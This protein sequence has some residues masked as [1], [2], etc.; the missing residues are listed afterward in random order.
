MI[1]QGKNEILFQEN[2]SAMIK[3]KVFSEPQID[4]VVFKISAFDLEIKNTTNVTTSFMATSLVITMHGVNVTMTGIVASFCIKQFTRNYVG[5]Y[6]LAVTN[7][8]AETVREFRIDL[9]GKV[10]Q[11]CLNDLN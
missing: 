4:N 10:K 7:S 5:T 6:N 8:K 3:L 11:I 2:V 1:L 9:K